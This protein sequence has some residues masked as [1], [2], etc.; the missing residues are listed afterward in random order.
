M[1]CVEG[2]YQ[3]H[4][5]RCQS[6]AN[7]DQLQSYHVVHHLGIHHQEYGRM[8]LQVLKEDLLHLIDLEW[9]IY[10]HLFWC[11]ISQPVRSNQIGGMV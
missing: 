8:V 11:L 5:P 7:L 4:F 6:E 9:R 1:P 3:I 10:T 2:F